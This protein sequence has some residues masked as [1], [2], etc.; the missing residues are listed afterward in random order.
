MCCLCFVSANSTVGIPVFSA[1]NKFSSG[2][3][4]NTSLKRLLS[5]AKETKDTVTATWVVV[6]GGEGN[7]H[8]T[9]KFC[10]SPSPWGGSVPSKADRVTLTVRVAI[11]DYVVFTS[12]EVSSK[13]EVTYKKMS[14]KNIIQ[15][16]STL[17]PTSSGR[18]HPMTL[19]KILKVQLQSHKTRWLVSAQISV[20]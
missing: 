5:D 9:Y 17:N 1:K 11:E 6:L 18:R 16:E 12:C 8:G 10:S 4:H 7:S 20:L 15:L 2:P 19:D 13:P 14:H 3:T